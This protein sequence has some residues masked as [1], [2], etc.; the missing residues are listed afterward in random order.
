MRLWASA[1]AAKAQ[2]ALAASR[3]QAAPIA[4]RVNARSVEDTI[5]AGADVDVDDMDTAE[6]MRALREGSVYSET[7]VPAGA[8]NENQDRQW[9]DGQWQRTH[10]RTRAGVGSSLFLRARSLCAAGEDPDAPIGG[11]T[12]ILRQARC[13]RGALAALFTL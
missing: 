12:I 1:E 2:A 6:E 4:D 11:T 3:S 10:A 13:A 9:S 5:A 7:V 8:G